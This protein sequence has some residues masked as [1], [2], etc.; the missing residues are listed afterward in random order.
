M[1]KSRVLLAIF[2]ASFIGIMSNP[3]MLTASDS[4]AVLGLS[5]D[6]IVETVVKAEP[7]VANV[8]EEID[9]PTDPVETVVQEVVYSEP[10]YEEPVYVAP[11]VEEPVYQLPA[12]YIQINGLTIP[13][14]YTDTTAE[15][16]GNAQL[17]WYYKTGKHI[18]GHNL[19]YVF[20]SL[21]WAHD[22][23]Y[24]DGMPFTVVM[25]GVANYYTV[26]THRVYDRLD[27]YTLG[28]NGDTFS[29]YPIVNA[30]LDGTYYRMTI[31]TC[32]NGSAQRLVLY[33]N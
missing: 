12:S 8:G 32:Y 4:V 28:Y 29:M 1:R 10:V 14:E 24:L 27:A 31:M 15:N 11:A 26:A 33:A 23:G 13:L 22:G 21:D 25:N 5:N 7:V 9:E 6:N 17:A 16:A 2:A 30:K 3:E 18:Y 19:D 20:G